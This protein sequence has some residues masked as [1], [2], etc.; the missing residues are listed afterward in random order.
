MEVIDENKRKKRTKKMPKI[1]RI[2]F[3]ITIILW[4]CS[5]AAL[6]QVPEK[7]LPVKSDADTLFIPGAILTCNIRYGNADPKQ[8]FDLYYPSASTRQKVPVIIWIHGG[9]WWTGGKKN[10]EVPYLV[11]HGYAIASIA[12]R[13]SQDSVF[14]AQ[15]RDCNAA[16]RYIRDHAAE[17]GLDTARFV[18]AGASAGGH[19]ASLAGMSANNHI[20]AFYPYP[21][22][23][24][25]SKTLIGQAAVS[26]ISIKAVINFYGPGDFYAFHGDGPAYK[27]DSVSSS[28]SRLLGASP[29]VRPDLAKWASPATYVDK[30][31]PPVLIL[32]GDKDPIIHYWL[33]E[34]FYNVLRTSGVKTSFVTLAGAGHGGPAFSDAESQQKVLAFLEEVLKKK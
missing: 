23:K 4:T 14:P 20:Q 12:Y 24:A 18:V 10:M 2:N 16:I 1:M 19:L 27:V 11:S 30:N 29:L 33:G 15:I 28:V 21:L 17:L 13:F 8:N 3:L 34:L 26:Q 7:K 25:S 22:K 5:V 32:H 6:A 9:G 31:D